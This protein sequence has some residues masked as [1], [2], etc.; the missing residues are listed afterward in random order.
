VVVLVKYIP[1]DKKIE[2]FVYAVVGLVILAI[3]MGMEAFGAMEY[4]GG[5]R[6]IT[7]EV[8][9]VA[10]GMVLVTAFIFAHE[11]KKTPISNRLKTV[12]VVPAYLLVAVMGYLSL[13]F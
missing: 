12:I 8:P 11:W 6:D 7:G 9:Y 2:N 13:A 5:R 1:V 10:A 3:F 4:T